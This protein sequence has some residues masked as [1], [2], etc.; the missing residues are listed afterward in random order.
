MVCAGGWAVVRETEYGG[1]AVVIKEKKPGPGEQFEAVARNEFDV[2]KTLPKLHGV[3]GVVG[4]CDTVPDTPGVP[5][6]VML[7]RVWCVV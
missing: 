5:H 4:V 7:V 6:L 2:L 1:R 3:V